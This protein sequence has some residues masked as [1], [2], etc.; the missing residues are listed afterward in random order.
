MY[1]FPL[2][3]AAVDKQQSD[4]SN[5]AYLYDRVQIAKG[6]KQLYA[7]QSTTNNG[8]VT[9]HFQPIEDES[10]VQKRRTEM[11][12]RLLGIGSASPT[13]ETVEAYAEALGF[14]Y[15]VPSKEEAIQRDKAWARAYEENIEMA[16]QAMK[17]K[18]FSNAID[19][20]NIAIQS[21][22]YIQT[23]DYVNLARAISISKHK[24][25][26]GAFYYLIKAAIRGYERIDE[27]DTHEDFENIKLANPD[28][29]LD[30]MTVVDE[31]KLMKKKTR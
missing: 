14:E 3:K 8:L 22:G 7:T 9:G 6:E 15:K 17:S 20:Y 16:Q 2:L 21:H 31:L 18:D 19:Y 29:W 5:Y 12:V 25:C 23:E 30:L 24:N 11:H 26:S 10:N 13:N 1:C 27:F 28:N 4:P